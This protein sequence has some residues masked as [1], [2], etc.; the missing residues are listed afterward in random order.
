[1]T[2]KPKKS[3]RG[4]YYDLSI[5]P[6]EYESPYG[7]LFKFPSEKQREIYCRNVQKEVEKI[8]KAF[9]RVGCKPFLH[10]NTV[11]AVFRSV[12]RSFYN[13]MGY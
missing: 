7:D 5:S 6:Y 10:S 9:E 2:N 3:R 4:Y 1:M 8:D 13:R 11:Q 12:Y